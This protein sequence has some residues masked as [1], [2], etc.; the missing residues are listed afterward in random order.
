MD[1]KTKTSEH[2]SSFMKAPF[3][4]APSWQLRHANIKY[5]Y[6]HMDKTCL[7]RLSG[8]RN[9]YSLK[10]VVYLC[11]AIWLIIWWSISL[12]Q[13]ISQRQ[14]LQITWQWLWAVLRLRTVYQALCLQVE[15]RIGYDLCRT[16]LVSS[17]S[18][19]Y[20]RNVLFVGFLK[21]HFVS[22]N[23]SLEMINIHE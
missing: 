1:C 22:V 17:A 18:Y 14:H 11:L 20:N 7:D 3:M 6:F 8:G 16:T 23:N 10:G 4:T 13:R 15:Y 9:C 5:L 2:D 12:S 19:H 21:N